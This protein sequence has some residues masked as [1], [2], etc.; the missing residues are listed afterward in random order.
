MC[1][2]QVRRKPRK[3]T[4]LIIEHPIAGRM[5]GSFWANKR[6]RLKAASFYCANVVSNYLGLYRRNRLA[7]PGFRDIIIGW[8]CTV[9]RQFI[10]SFGEV[11]A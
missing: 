8:D 10:D 1:S 2:W 4:S 7:P 5:G 9:R 3:R 6:G 11:A